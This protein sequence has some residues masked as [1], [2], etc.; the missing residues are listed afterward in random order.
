MR[1]DGGYDVIIKACEALGAPG[2]PAKHIA[3]YVGP[4]TLDYPHV[5]FIELIV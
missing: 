2:V 1:E 5:W 4:T 3:A